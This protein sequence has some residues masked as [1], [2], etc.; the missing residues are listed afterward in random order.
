[1]NNYEGQGVD[2]LCACHVFSAKNVKKKFLQTK[3]LA[4]RKNSKTWYA[5]AIV[6][7]AKDEG[8]LQ[9]SGSTKQK[10]LTTTSKF[11]FKSFRSVSASNFAKPNVLLLVFRDVV[12]LWEFPERSVKFGYPT[13]K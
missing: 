4:K 9:L 8:T 3:C 11:P 7:F 10:E 13:L 5:Y 6:N 1:M 2:N 12:H